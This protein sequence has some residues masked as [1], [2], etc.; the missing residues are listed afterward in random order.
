[1]DTMTWRS[2]TFGLQGCQSYG[3]KTTPFLKEQVIVLTLN[4]KPST[5][6]AAAIHEYTSLFNFKFISTI[7]NT[8]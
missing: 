8:T 3:P 2:K 4:K 5:T 7:V 6:F 1:M